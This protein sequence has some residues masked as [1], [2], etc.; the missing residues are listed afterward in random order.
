M[1]P[2]VYITKNGF[3]E[4]TGTDKFGREIDGY[5]VVYDS[6][7]IPEEI[8]KDDGAFA[9]WGLKNNAQYIGNYRKGEQIKR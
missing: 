2:M 3:A 7:N 5:R 8:L 4:V 1:K 9:S 6:K